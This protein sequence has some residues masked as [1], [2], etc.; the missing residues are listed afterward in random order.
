MKNSQ[1]SILHGFLS[2]G[3]G[4]AVGFFLIF[5]AT[6][7]DLESSAYDFPRLASAGLGGLH[8]PVLMT[9]NETGTIS[10]D[11]SNKTDSQISPAIKTLVSTR[12]LP[13]EFLEGVQL[14]PGEAERLEWSVDAENIDLGRFIFAKVLLYSAYPVPSREA[15]CG[16]FILGLPGSGKII[17][18]ALVILSLIGMGWGLHHINNLGVPNE[19]LKKPTGSMTFLALMISLGL[20]LSFIGGWIAS[21][22]VLVTSLLLII[23]LISSLLAGVSK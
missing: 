6:W 1:L 16:I 19:R 3:I 5:V 15:T 23:I 22:L 7:A 13:E 17:V 11:V 14:T 10:L 8:C 21:S 20:V 18:P 4:V 2:Y 9:L 12:L